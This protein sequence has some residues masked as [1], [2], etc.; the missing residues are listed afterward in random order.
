MIAITGATGQLGRLVIEDLLKKISAGEIIALVR[1]PE[2]A[3]DLKQRGVEVRRADYTDLPSM[4]SAFQGADK[5]LLISSNVLGQRE[6][7]HKAAIDAAKTAGVRLVA[8]TSILRADTTPLEIAGEHLA[9]EQYLRASG[10]GFVMLRNGWY[11]ENQTVAIAPSVANGAFIGAS[12]EG[13]YAAAARADFA[14]AAAIVLTEEGHEN[15]VYELAGDNP[16]TR[17][18][19]A[20]EV[21]RQV[22]KQI[23]YHDLPEAEY[24]KILAGFLPPALA[25]AT[26]D[27][28]AKA[29]AGA[30]DDD[31]HIL[32]RL[33]GRK[34]TSLADAVAEAIKNPPAAH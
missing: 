20:A 1:S 11:F 34:T 19:L 23:P 16:Y 8:Y 33:I 26:A 5:L 12:G 29:A 9:T 7:Q 4:V 25:H 14:E 31:S 27:A 2:N 6:M 18:E 22:G 10:L 17:A 15:K 13:R 3:A 24:E 30:L 28:E 21:S 32:S